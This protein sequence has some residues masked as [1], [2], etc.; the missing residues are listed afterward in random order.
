MT[1]I[2]NSSPTYIKTE[3]DFLKCIQRK[4]D[5]EIL[6]FLNT[7]DEKNTVLVIEN[8][9][10]IF[11][12]YIFKYKNIEINN[13]FFKLI[14]KY[15]TV[16]FI[17]YM[18]T[19]IESD[20]NIPYYEKLIWQ[21]NDFSSGVHMNELTFANIIKKMPD[22]KML[23]CM[24]RKIN[25]TSTSKA[26]FIWDI[27]S[28][29]P[30]HL[31]IYII[32]IMITNIKV[33]HNNNNTNNLYTL[34]ATIVF[35]F[36]NPE[37]ELQ[38]N[39]FEYI[40]F[41]H[42]N[43]SYPIIKKLIELLEKTNQYE[44]FVIANSNINFIILHTITNNELFQ[45]V[46][47]D[48]FFPY[49]DPNFKGCYE[50][51][52]KSSILEACLYGD[53]YTQL[54]WFIE[55]FPNLN[56]NDSFGN[57]NHGSEWYNKSFFSKILYQ[58]SVYEYEVNKKN[59]IS[60][61]YKQLEKIF[62]WFLNNHIGKSDLNLNQIDILGQYFFDKIYESNPDIV[63]NKINEFN[64]VL[65]KNNN[66]DGL[67][68]LEQ[69]MS[70]IENII[71]Y[72]MALCVECSNIDS[73]SN[74]IIL[75]IIT[76][77]KKFNIFNTM[78]FTKTNNILE[79]FVII[80]EKS[81][82]ETIIIFFESIIKNNIENLIEIK[83]NNFVE[84][85]S[86]QL[87]NNKSNNKSNKKKITKSKETTNSHVNLNVDPII[88]KISLI[89][90]NLVNACAKTKKYEFVKDLFSNKNLQIYFE[91]VHDNKTFLQLFIME[92][93]PTDFVIDFM[94]TMNDKCHPAYKILKTSETALILA[95]KAK[96][97]KIVTKLIEIF[98]DNLY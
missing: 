88:T 5:N 30:S 42:K 93:Y 11:F 95:S 21:K 32:D 18:L 96:N 58:I 28:T 70:S 37:P 86:D 66:I 26:N 45:L 8:N 78:P 27:C 17:E 9:R 22:I 20:T 31:I 16:D 74:Q 64:H 90:Y 72:K 10:Q 13:K 44:D 29:Y 40:V 79:K 92:N 68:K 6:N 63:K 81:S 69:T 1:N 97:H 53:A 12:N 57:I 39:M 56:L 50:F 48:N 65:I 94:L 7:C 76:Q 54:L 33:V 25:W 34:L 49:I 41:R 77:L 75:W 91:P 36:S 83:K 14:E 84:S 38:L 71:N 85:N 15:A 23:L 87:S 55:K 3:S 2:K 35:T 62:N 82:L 47:R 61:K 4:Y 89:F 51:T 67:N 46:W 19:G 24:L 98:D 60:D 43:K 80:C 52:S 73:S 59:K